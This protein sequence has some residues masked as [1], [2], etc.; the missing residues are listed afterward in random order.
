MAAMGEGSNP[1]DNDLYGQELYQYVTENLPNKVQSLAIE[2]SDEGVILRGSCD[3]YYSKQVAQEIVSKST[4]RRIVS[5]LIEVR[6]S[7][8]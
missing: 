7:P 6:D 4:S 3:S 8:R 2:V 5:N 1:N